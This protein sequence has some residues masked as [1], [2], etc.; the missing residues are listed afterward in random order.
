VD[1]LA[2]YDEFEDALKARNG[3]EL[4]VL[5]FKDYLDKRGGPAG[6]SR[7]AVITGAGLIITGKSSMTHWS[8]TSWDLSRSPRPS[9][10]LEEITGFK[11]IIFRVDSPA[12]RPW[13][14]TDLARNAARAQGRQ[15]AH[16]LDVG[17]RRFGRLLRLGRRRQDCRPAG[18]ITGSIGVVAGKMVTTG[19][20]D[21]IGLNREPLQLGNHAAYYY[22]GKRYSDEEKAIYWRFMH[23]IY[24]K[25]TGLVARAGHDQRRGGQGRPGACLVG[26]RAKQLGLIDELGG[27]SEAIALAKK[28]AGIPES[29]E[30]R[31]VYLPEKRSLIQNLLFPEEPAE[32]RISIPRE[33]LSPLQEFSRLQIL[34]REK[35]FL[36][37]DPPASTQ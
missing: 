5:R 33:L 16:H 9:E 6:R 1:H 18:T 26:T 15:A 8:A 10:R 31:L 7:I 12:A 36:L 14:R 29:E 22:D 34:G 37:A 13:P 24:D 17:C 32:A 21:W 30:V 20:Y 28:Q 4:A 25:F 11:A 27:M 35:V 23:K 3:G 19:F 2:Y